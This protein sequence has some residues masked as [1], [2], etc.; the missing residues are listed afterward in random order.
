MKPDNRKA[1]NRDK[2][3]DQEIQE[4]I[5]QDKNKGAAA[6]L[7]TYTGLLWSVCARRLQN[8]EDIRE[9]VNDAFSE[10]FLHTDRY[11]EA[12][13]SLRNY[14]CLIADRKALNRYRDNCRRERA[15]SAASGEQAWKEDGQEA[16]RAPGGA[17]DGEYTREELEAAIDKLDPMDSQIIRMK[18][19]QGLSYQEIAEKLALNYE[20]VKKR[21]QR[22]LKKLWKILVIGL[23]ILLLAACAVIVSRYFQFAEGVGFSWSEE[24]PIYRMTEVS[25]PCRADG[26]TFSVDNVAYRDGHM[27]FSIDYKTDKE[28]E[29]EEEWARQN[30]VYQTYI[31]ALEVKDLPLELCETKHNYEN[32]QLVSIWQP[33]EELP[34]S[35]TIEITLAGFGKNPDEQV[36]NVVRGEGW[37]SDVETK[38]LNLQGPNPKFTVTLS[39]VSVQEDVSSVGAVQFFEDT[40]FVVC[41][42]TRSEERTRFSL[43]A[44]NEGI[45]GG[46]YG[47]S[48]FLVNSTNMVSLTGADGTVWEANEIECG[49]WGLDEMVLSFPPL[50]PGEY[51]MTIPYLRMESSQISSGAYIPLPREVGETVACDESLLFPDGTGYRL[52]GVRM[53]YYEAYE[54]KIYEEDGERL[55]TQDPDPI[56]EYELMLEP[57]S[58]EK[59]FFRHA[60]FEARYFY[61]NKPQEEAGASF[62][63]SRERELELYPEGSRIEVG[64]I[65]M[66]GVF[67]QLVQREGIEEA[68]DWVELRL[69]DPVYNYNRIF[70]VKVIVE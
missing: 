39:R 14:L 33:E 11:D 8:P 26:F 10:F 48:T 7:E 51:T 69:S 55:V 35:F 67:L 20:T 31:N 18:Y 6:L 2:R 25:D 38:P 56:F 60:T 44:L 1:D 57:I 43:Y 17:G 27:Y 42:G 36:Y 59:L 68:P 40:G 23:I 5:K 13:S 70:Q 30:T 28:P 64:S 65:H 15:E 50:E 49:F 12:K 52:T 54:D 45:D 62:E 53:K 22:S 3:E 4:L 24:N 19:Y 34:E 37:D 47:F 61:G 58:T 46:K 32:M 63:L 66:G 41:P 29:G 9:C 21:G 16:F